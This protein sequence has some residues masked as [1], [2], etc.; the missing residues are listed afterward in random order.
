MK[1]SILFAALALMG[2]LAFSEPITRASL[3]KNIAKFMGST[4]G[5]LTFTANID[6]I[7]GTFFIPR[8]AIQSATVAEFEGIPIAVFCGSFQLIE[9]RE[10][11]LIFANSDKMDSKGIQINDVSV[12]ASGNIAFTKK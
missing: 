5:C 4:N 8:T 9:N 11:A 7:T 3:E 6:E 2:M 12:D 10:S 1:K